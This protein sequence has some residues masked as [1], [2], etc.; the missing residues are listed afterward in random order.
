MAE[1][2]ACHDCACSHPGFSPRAAC[3]GQF[4]F[5]GLLP[6]LC[7]MT[8]TDISSIN[9]P[10]RWVGRIA[11]IF[12]PICLMP[13]SSMSSVDGP[14]RMIGH[15]AYM[16]FPIV[17]IGGFLGWLIAPKLL[18]RKYSKTLVWQFLFSSFWAIGAVTWGSVVVYFAD[19]SPTYNWK[20]G[21]SDF[22]AGF[23]AFECICLMLT[24]VAGHLTR[25]MFRKYGLLE[26]TPNIAA[27]DV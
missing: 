11:Y 22:M 13:F 5:V 23:I 1:K 9:G 21:L 3:A 27:N 4:I 24:L 17:I 25:S 20:N 26:S 18:H 6:T 19:K 7:L 10:L 2:A 8:F 16:F 12:S 15:I 14:L